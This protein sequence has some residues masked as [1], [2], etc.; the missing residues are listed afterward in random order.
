M[1]VDLD[2]AKTISKGQV[3]EF[4]GLIRNFQEIGGIHIYLRNVE[5]IQIV[6]P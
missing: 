3:I 2:V 1:D 6:N 4:K 5:L